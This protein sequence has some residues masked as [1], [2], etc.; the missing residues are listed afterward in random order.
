[1]RV[2][3]I[4]TEDL[5][6]LRERINTQLQRLAGAGDGPN[7][8]V[9]GAVA[10]SITAP[11]KRIRAMLVDLALLDL[12][13]QSAD[14]IGAGCAVELVHTA[15]LLLDD[16]PCMD[17]AQTRRGRPAL[18]LA[19]GEDVAILAAVALLG[20]AFGLIARLD[21]VGAD[22]RSAMSAALSE[23]IG[24]SGLV[25]GQFQDLRQSDSYRDDGAT[26][27][28][29]RKTGA[30]FV[31]ALLMG[32]HLAGAGQKDQRLLREA[33]LELGRA[34]QLYDDL[35]DVAGDPRKMGKDVSKDRG[36]VLLAQFLDTDAMLS[37]IDAHA[38]NA[39]AAFAALPSGGPRLRQF[40]HHIFGALAVNRPAGRVA[41]LMPNLMG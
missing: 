34:F 32:A 38:E 3:A 31:A 39:S 24:V 16:L 35:L 6:G 40:L 4:V 17:D 21:G 11:G 5:D 41:G 20:D 28:N 1:M 10:E 2:E 22:A 12:G 25:G 30:L 14:A 29:D 26:E 33:G 36:K 13:G 7:T 18:H 9:R 37:Q 8:L 15:S 19:F 27:A 23:A